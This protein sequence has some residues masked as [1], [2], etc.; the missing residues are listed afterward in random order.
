ML[1][2]KLQLYVTCALDP[3]AHTV[4]ISFPSVGLT[5]AFNIMKPDIK[6]LQTS[7]FMNF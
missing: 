3:F 5:L 7:I 6:I 2:F 1:F 4:L